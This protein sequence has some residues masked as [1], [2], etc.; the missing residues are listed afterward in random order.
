[1]KTYKTKILFLALLSFVLF[2][3][4]KD[5]DDDL[6]NSDLTSY[7]INIGQ[8][9][10]LNS[11]KNFRINLDKEITKQA[12]IQ[13]VGDEFYRVLL[14][15]YSSSYIA[16][17]TA[18]ALRKKKLIDNYSI[19]KRGK[20]VLDE[21]R[22]ILFVA[23][24]EGRPS[25]YNFD[26]LTKKTTAFWSRWGSRV[27]SLNSSNDRGVAFITTALAYG[28]RGG[29]PYIVD[30]RESRLDREKNECE[31]VAQLGDGVQLYTY[32]ESPDTFKVNVS[33]ID[34][35]N[36]RN[37]FQKIFPFSLDGKLSGI[38]NRQFDILKNGFP[39]PPK[40]NPI[41]FSPNNRFQ[42]REAIFRNEY[43]YY[44]KDIKDKSDVLVA[45]SK[46]KI[47]DARWSEDGN[48][49]FIITHNAAQNY[50]K[51]QSMSSGELIV[52]DAVQK[53]KV[54]VFSGFRYG[55][56]LVQGDFILFDERTGEISKINVLDYVNNE[57]YCTIAIPGG[58]GLNNL[59]LR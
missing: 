29:F 3:S 53:K 27:V 57:I 15:R 23:T 36:S 19:Y 9:S 52:I 25:V 46:R 38:V 45:T 56:I 54:N 4:C 35:T 24:Y 20:E 13:K 12:V 48:Y 39:S 42:L 55:N 22:N 33:I 6:A 14:G 34:T 47:S 17:K 44:I 11:A 30:I 28:Q 43:I 58:C 59:P 37:V 18:Y 8:F 50:G 1:M 21:F 51:K 10:T 26:L 31:E 32:W 41:Y 16:G 40:L 7:Y 5:T 49:L 2:S